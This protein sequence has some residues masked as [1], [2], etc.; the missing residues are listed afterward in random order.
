MAVC[1]AGIGGLALAVVLATYADSSV[2]VAV[3]EGAP[4]ITT[5]GAGISVWKRTWRIMQLLGL[6]AELA[7][8][9]IE[10]PDDSP[11]PGLAFRRSD[12]LYAGYDF[13]QMIMPYGAITLHRADVVDILKRKIPNRYSVSTS[14]RVKTYTR[15]LDGSITLHFTDGSLANCDVLVGADGIHSRIRQSMFRRIAEH[16]GVSDIAELDSIQSKTGPVWTGTLAY[17]SLIP[18]ETLESVHPGHQACV[19][20]MAYL[21]KDKHFIAYPVSQGRFINAVGFY[22]VPRAEGTPFDGT[23]VT[24]V[25]RQEVM[26]CFGAFEPEVQAIAKCMECP[27]RWAIHSM[28]SLPH[29]AYER[30]AII[31]DAAHAMTTHLGAG[32]GQAME[33]AYVLGRMLAHPSLTLDKIPDALRIYEEIRLPFANTVVKES[34]ITGLLYEFNGTMYDGLDR[35]KEREELHTLAKQIEKQW[36]WHWTKEFD[37]DWERAE[38]LLSDVLG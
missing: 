10:P 19:R 8:K 32:A 37:E 4:A 31:G 11:R 9:A 15:E 28:A 27:S 35:S 23:W 25:S 20:A 33:D 17:R 1:G 13:Y 16:D 3:Y 5:V 2:E 34:E 12:Q 30:V 7:K 14:K 38:T 26:D 22:T 29:Y 36:E 21:G 6:D 24:D 18:K